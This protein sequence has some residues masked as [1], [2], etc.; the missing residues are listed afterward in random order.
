[1]GTVV[2]IPDSALD[3]LHVLWVRHAGSGDIIGWWYHPNEE[4]LKAKEVEIDCPGV[5]TEIVRYE[6]RA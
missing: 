5:T 6:R 1:M 3:V 2:T 4:A